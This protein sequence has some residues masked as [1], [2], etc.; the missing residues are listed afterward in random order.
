MI[1]SLLP[2]A[3]GDQTPWT[4]LWSLMS[5][6]LCTSCALNPTGAEADAP[7]S[8]HSA[9]NGKGAVENS[10]HTDHRLDSR[11]TPEKTL[12]ALHHSA[13]V[14]DEK[15]Y[16]G[17]FTP[18]AVFLGTDASERW[19]I[20]EL[21][22]FAL[23][24]FQRESAWTYIPRDRNVSMLPGEE[25]AFFDEILDQEKYGE[26]RGS[27]VLRVVG[28]RWLIA[29]YHLTFPIPNDLAGAITSTIQGESPP[30]RWVI[31]VRHAEKEKTGADPALSSQGLLRARNLAKMLSSMTIDACFATEY[32]RTLET[33]TPAAKE[34]GVTITRVP[35]RQLNDLVAQLDALESPSLA[36][37][38]GHSNTV[39][40]ILKALGC[41]ENVTL[42]ESEYGDLFLIRRGAFATDLLK[43]RF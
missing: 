32:R 24:Y 43:F 18:E 5:I 35:A 37:V 22:A 23:P 12:D 36:L 21:R 17:L 29:Q 33:V 9:T 39:P 25:V 42:D 30:A 13:A 16:F 20:E 26:C 34:G 10:S 15:T 31:V 2:I 28:G 4:I 7:R 3:T 14:A 38:A 19:T 11:S 8:H 40:R 27:G 41:S 6:L 1:R